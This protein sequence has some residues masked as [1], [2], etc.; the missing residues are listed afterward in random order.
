M[1]MQKEE[2]VQGEVLENQQD[3]SD[4]IQDDIEK[5]AEQQSEAEP[6]TNESAENESEESNPAEESEAQESEDAADEENEDADEEDAEEEL[7]EEPEEEDEPEEEEEADQPAKEVAPRSFG[8]IFLL[9]MA[10]MMHILLLL[11]T[12]GMFLLGDAVCGALLCVAWVLRLTVS[13]V[14][15]HKAER[16]VARIGVD[17]TEL[18]KKSEADKKLNIWTYIASAIALL[19]F[20]ALAGTYIYFYG[21]NYELVIGCIGLMLLTCPAE[22]LTFFKLCRAEKTAGI[23]DGGSALC[24]GARA[25]RDAGFVVIRESDVVSDKLKFAKI[26]TYYKSFGLKDSVIGRDR[27]I[28]RTILEMTVQATKVKQDENG[29][30]KGNKEE[31]A[32][33]NAAAAQAVYKEAIDEKFVRKFVLKGENTVTFGHKI[34]DG[35]RLISKGDP[36]EILAMCDRVMGDGEVLEATDSIVQEITERAEA[37]CKEG[38]HVCALAFGDY[39]GKQKKDTNDKMFLGLLVCYYVP[40][41]SGVSA[42]RK[43][44]SLGLKP[45]LFSKQSAEKTAVMLKLYKDEAVCMIKEQAEPEN[46]KDT[47]A[48]C[49]MTPEKEQ[50]ILSVYK[51]NGKDVL[52]F[53]QKGQNKHLKDFTDAAVL[54]GSV[55]DAETYGGTVRYKSD[56][57]DFRRKLS[58]YLYSEKKTLS[59]LTTVKAFLLLFGLAVCLIT[60]KCPMLFSQMFGIGLL[61]EICAMHI[62]YAPHRKEKICVNG[63]RRGLL[64]TV[65]GILA[66][67]VVTVSYIFGRYTIPAGSVVLAE[68][69]AAAMSFLVALT[70]VLLLAL[71]SLSHKIVFSFGF[72]T[73]KQVWFLLV[74]GAV[75][76]AALL[77]VPAV[78]SFVAIPVVSLEKGIWIGAFTA[79][80]ALASDLLKVIFCRVKE[81]D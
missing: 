15:L 18:Y 69:F 53:V 58:S 65:F 61:T 8:K 39:E 19:I 31:L 59:F 2:K 57:G 33:I 63:K 55:K 28:F 64:I 10:D 60:F 42:I 68:Q 50:Q 36:K 72:V 1:S 16:R 78:R 54:V 71:S 76:A 67:A 66:F 79:V 4:E 34:P 26:D 77:Y 38:A 74:T 13:S 20:G 7:P 62:L 30:Y 80:F 27:P 32:W 11:G 37:Y 35:I 46:L 75:L 22:L 21:M 48:Y 44:E 6:E 29:L 47:D 25:I 24:Q 12:I 9:Q 51:D 45:L 14:L 81:K 56:I 3:L 49:D 73:V 43:Y 70:V 40:N 5:T 17:A 41:T 23:A 52:V